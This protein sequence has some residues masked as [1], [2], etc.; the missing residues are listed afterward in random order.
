MSFELKAKL[1][2][3]KITELFYISWIILLTGSRYNF[4]KIV[5][6]KLHLFQKLLKRSNFELLENKELQMNFCKINYF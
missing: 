1:I 6:V 3:C 2:E 5:L 4:K